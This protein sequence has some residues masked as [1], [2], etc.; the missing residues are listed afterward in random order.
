MM[1]VRAVLI[2]LLL[3]S[4]AGCTGQQPPESS[5]GASPESG[6][7]DYLAKVKPILD[8]RCVVCH[9]CYNSPCQLKLDSHEGLDRGGS[10]EKVYNSKRLWTMEPS[11]L[12]T[13]YQSTEDWRKHG[14]HS[15]T[16]S[17]EEDASDSIMMKLLQQKKQIGS[18]VC[19]DDVNAACNSFKPE[20]DTL[21]CAATTSQV[22]DYL[23]KHPNRGMPYGFPPLSESEFAMVS[24]WLKDGA[25]GPTVEQRQQRGAIVEGDKNKVKDWE[26]FFNK[27]SPDPGLYAKYRM[28]A[29]YLYEHLFLAHIIFRPESCETL[30]A[31]GCGVYE[32][33]RSRTKEGPVDVIATVRPYDDPETDQFY[34]RFRRIHSTIVFKTHMVFELNDAK[35][36]RFNELFYDTNWEETPHWIGFDRKKSANP[37]EAFAQIPAKSRYQFLLDNNYFIIQSF[38]HGPVCKGQVALNVVQDNFWLFFLDPEY[39]LTVRNKNFL[40]DNQELVTIPTE[41]GNYFSHFKFIILLKIK[42]YRDFG[43]AYLKAR[44]Q[45]YTHHY[46]EKGIGPLPQEAIWA[47]NSRQDSPALTVFRHFDSGTAHKGL[48]GDLPKTMWVMDFPLMERIYYALVAGFDVYGTKGHQASVRFYMDNLRQEG[49]TYFLDFLPKKARRRLMQE[50]YGETKLEDIGYTPS[51]LE[52]A[53]TFAT[54]EYKRELVETLVKNGHFRYHLD[55][56][57]DAIGNAIAFDQNYRHFRQGWPDLP[58]DYREDSDKDYIQAFQVV[59]A[60]GTRFFSLIKDYD[61]NL[62]Y[63]RIRMPSGKDEVVSIVVHRWHDDVLGRMDEEVKLNPDKDEADFFRNTMI[64]C[65]P[66][67]FFVVDLADLP[68]FLEMLYTYDGSDEAVKDLLKFGVNRASDDFW[69]H[70]DWFQQRFDQEHKHLGGRLDLNRYYHLAVKEKEAIG[71]GEH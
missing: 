29:R 23:A 42:K 3:L 58:K 43:Y 59:S 45:I 36:A 48:L 47:G 33:V 20:S 37:F 63:V 64:G 67:Y 5:G 62:A 50:W 7:A 57:P 22:D 69:N 4:L 49:E 6:S 54:R 71:G 24:A 26:E 16:E 1:N 40:I 46:E 52:A 32:L 55:T 34:Y 12:F 18:S 66:N 53:M 30:D 38:I 44:Q 21:T 35:M 41:Q 27:S 31:E 61:A 19:D 68:K 65:Y 28:T 9:S 14:F 56:S 10:K 39:D 17:K 60:P 11:R 25:R 2:L 8:A 13:D 51:E 70:Y 15:V